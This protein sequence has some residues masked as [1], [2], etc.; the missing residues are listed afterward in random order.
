[1]APSYSPIPNYIFF[2]EIAA[3]NNVPA[4]SGSTVTV[5]IIPSATATIVQEMGYFSNVPRFGS[6]WF[7]ATSYASP[8]LSNAELV[9]LAVSEMELKQGK[10]KNFRDVKS[11]LDD[12]NEE[13]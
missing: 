5:P 7:A 10:G 9:D 6:I 3:S 12:L 8:P 11:L 13:D 4:F 2:E 1:V